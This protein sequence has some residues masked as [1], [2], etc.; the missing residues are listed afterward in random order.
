VRYQQRRDP[1]SGID[2]R[3]VSGCTCLRARRIARQLTQA[4]DRA[5]ESVDLTVNQLGVLAKLYGATRGG[6]TGVPIGALADRLGMHPTTLNRDLK[7]LRA[8]GLI[9][10]A[11]DAGDRRVRAVTMTAKGRARLTKAIPVWRRAQKRLEAALGADTAR[12][13]NEVLDVAATKLQEGA[14]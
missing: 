8:Q 1:E 7:P 3:D 5:L 12:A 14:T 11:V 2:L 13:L 4:Y 10:D 6:R 9:A